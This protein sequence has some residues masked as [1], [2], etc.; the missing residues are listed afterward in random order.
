MLMILGFQHEHRTQTHWPNPTVEDIHSHY[1]TCINK[2]QA[3][4]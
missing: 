2:V 3:I 1:S 4:A